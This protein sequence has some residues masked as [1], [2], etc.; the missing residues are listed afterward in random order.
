MDRLVGS[1]CEA[2]GVTSLQKLVNDLDAQNCFAEIESLQKIRANRETLA[3]VL[4][5]EREWMRRNSTLREQLQ[6]LIPVPSLNPVKRMQ[7]GF[8]ATVQAREFKLDQLMFQLASRAYE[9]EVGQRPKTLADLV[10]KY[11]K[12]VPVTPTTGTNDSALIWRLI[13]S[14]IDNRQ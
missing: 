8:A 12:T 4:L 1:A 11:L 3:D 9:I 7:Q 2:I 13:S 14:S 6:S 10:P 5:H